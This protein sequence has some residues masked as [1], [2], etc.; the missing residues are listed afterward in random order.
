MHER[1][2]EAP[3]GNIEGH[4]PP[5]I[6]LGLEGQPHLADDLGPHVQRVARRLPRRQ[7]KLRPLRPY[8]QP[9]HRSRVARTRRR[10]RTRS[11]L[12]LDRP[13]IGGMAEDLPPA[14]LPSVF[15]EFG[16]PIAAAANTES[17][18]LKRRTPHPRPDP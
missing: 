10:W 12:S 4:L 14:R 6:N 13:I 15:A 5:V 17:P 7:V 16:T 2:G 8:R 3:P 18:L 9:S 1:G 11:D